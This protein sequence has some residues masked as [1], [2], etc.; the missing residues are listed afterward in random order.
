MYISMHACSMMAKP[1]KFNRQAACRVAEEANK[2]S[3]NAR[4]WLFE[5]ESV[6]VAVLDG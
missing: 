3:A 4:M 1:G 6:D 5:A 2:A